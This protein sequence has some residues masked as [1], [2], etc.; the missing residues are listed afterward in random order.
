MS[1]IHLEKRC[2]T[3]LNFY[4]ILRP[5]F[6]LRSKGSNHS[7]CLGR[8][9]KRIEDVAELDKKEKLCLSAIALNYFAMV[10]RKNEAYSNEM[11]KNTKNLWTN[12]LGEIKKISMDEEKK[13]VLYNIPILKVVY[14]NEKVD[15]IRDENEKTISVFD[16]IPRDNKYMILSKREG[17]DRHRWTQKLLKIDQ[18]K[19][20]EIKEKIRRLRSRK[21][22]VGTE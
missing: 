8:L 6:R 3:P 5:N 2:L 13:T 7:I 22:T 20:K 12:L 15:I 1:V 18:D 17:Q 9:Y 16:I 19:Y 21:F 11:E 4:A 14:K 10:N